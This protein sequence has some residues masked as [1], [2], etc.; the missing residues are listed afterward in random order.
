MEEYAR[1]QTSE[2]VT[3]CMASIRCTCCGDEMLP[4]SCK[5]MPPGFRRERRRRRKR[6]VLGTREPLEACSHGWCSKQTKIASN[7]LVFGLCSHSN[8]SCITNFVRASLRLLAWPGNH[9]EACLTVSTTTSSI[10][11]TTTS[12]TCGYL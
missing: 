5:R 2:K 4:M 10:S 9:V 8:A 11:T 1:G 6:N 3:R 12:S 7:V